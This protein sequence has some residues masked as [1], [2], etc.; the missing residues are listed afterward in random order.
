MER[1]ISYHIYMIDHI[2]PLLF[3]DNDIVRPEKKS[4]ITLMK[5]LFWRGNATHKK[6]NTASYSMHLSFPTIFL[7]SLQLLFWWYSDNSSF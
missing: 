3:L 4:P 7:F 6:K 5:P 1:Y 2:M